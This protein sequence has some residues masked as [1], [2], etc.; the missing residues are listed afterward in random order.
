VSIVLFQSFLFTFSVTRIL[1]CHSKARE[2]SLTHFEKAFEIAIALEEREYQMKVIFNIALIYE[3]SKTLD[4]AED[5]YQKIIEID[6]KNYHTMV[7]LVRL[8]T[9]WTRHS[10]FCVKLSLISPKQIHLDRSSCYLWQLKAVY[11]AS[12]YIASALTTPSTRRRLSSP[13]IMKSLRF[14]EPASSGKRSTTSRWPSS[15]YAIISI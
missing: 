15:C 11:W 5:Q 10:H 14:N 13:T 2:K 7:S 1:L 4:K 12:V 9:N 3:E 8:R 6:S